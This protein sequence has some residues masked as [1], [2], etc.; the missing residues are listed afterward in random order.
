MFWMAAAAGMQVLGA[1]GQYKA[2]KANAKAARAI[3]E[4][5]NKMLS[6][7]NA[8]NQ[9]AITTNTTLAIQQSARQA[10]YMRADELSTLGS[11]AVAAA[12][13]GVRGRSVNQTLLAV[14]RNAGLQEAQ[15]S[16]DLQQQFLQFDQQRLSSSLDAVNGQDLSY[17]PKPQLGSYLM[18]AATNIASSYAMKG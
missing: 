8:L 6:I 4:Y 13:A 12:A 5:K 17:I 15:R 16:T 18:K 10:V 2:D 14:Q 7:S 9:N 1:I 3:Q 11:T